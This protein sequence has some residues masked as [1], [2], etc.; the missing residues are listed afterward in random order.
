MLKGKYKTFLVVV[1]LLTYVGQSLAAANI[2]CK[3]MASKLAHFEQSEKSGACAAH[4]KYLSNDT[5]KRTNSSDCCPHCD[6]YLGGCSNTALPV[7]P[8]TVAHIR[9]PILVDGYAAATSN[10]FAL[11]LFRP[12][13]TC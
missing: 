3:N 10:P 9:S 11:S 7:T 1:L 2:T 4:S 12:P 5:G 13:I 6:C 8:Q